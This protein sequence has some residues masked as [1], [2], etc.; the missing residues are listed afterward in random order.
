M[1]KILLLLIFVYSNS[2][3]S[4]TSSGMEQEFDYGIK[5]N[6]TQT[7]TTP[8]YLGTFGTDGTQGKI[9]SAYIEK[10]DNKQN[11]LAI[12]GMGTKYPTVDAVNKNL[13]YVNA[14]SF[15]VLGDG[16]TDDS[17]A[18]QNAINS[19]NIVYFPKGTYNFNNIVVPSNSRIIGDGIGITNFFLN[20]A[21]N[22]LFNI[23][24]DITTVKQNI[25]FDAISFKHSKTH[26]ISGESGVFIVAFR[27]KNSGI[28]N[29]E[30]SEFNAYAIHSQNVDNN[31][32]KTEGITVSN[33]IFRN[34]G[35]TSIGVYFDTETEYSTVNNC[36]FHDLIAVRLINSANNIINGN[37]MLN[38]G[39]YSQNDATLNGGKITFTNNKV[40][41]GGS[42][43]I[44][45][46]NTTSIFGSSIVGN[47]FLATATNGLRLTGGSGNV[48]VGNRFLPVTG[49][50]I[51]LLDYLGVPADN[52]IIT[53]NISVNAEL[54]DNLST[55]VN[56]SIINNLE[57]NLPSDMK[58]HYVSKNLSIGSIFDDGIN[59]LQVNGSTKTTA[60]TLTTTPTTSAG[61]YG[62]LTRNSSTGVVEKVLS[63]S[64]QPALG[65][66]PEN[67]AN[68]SDS[69]TA[70]SSITYASTKAVVDGL[71]TKAPT[72][73]SANYIQNQNASAQSANMW[74]SGDVTANVL[75]SNFEPNNYID[76]YGT[77]SDM[78]FNSQYG[79]PNGGFKFKHAGS[80]QFSINADNSA[81]FASTVT[82]RVFISNDSN[83]GYNIDINK[84]A[85]FGSSLSIKNS[86]SSSNSLIRF[87]KPNNIEFYNL[88]TSSTGIELDG[89]IS[90]TGGTTANQVV[91]K[92]QL[93]GKVS[94]TGNETVAGNKTLSGTTTLN[95]TIIREGYQ[96]KFPKGV[97][98]QSSVGTNALTDN[99]TVSFPDASGT[100]A[101]VE[102]VRPYKVYTAL[103]SQSGT[104]APTATVLENTLA[105]TVVWTR[106]DIGN[107]TATLTGAFPSNKVVV[108][109]TNQPTGGAADNFK[110]G[111][112]TNDTITVITTNGTSSTDS[113]L[114]NSSIEIRV[115]L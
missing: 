82:A 105:G 95:E 104:N 46:A 3:I 90:A 88:Y 65:Y 20:S 2:S 111:R 60:L 17:V 72:T 100:V 28:N 32:T 73:G 66:T 71:A 45:N 68:K 21:T 48:V 1:K 79:N 50:P 23:S 41:H 15:G 19:A 53:G 51:R 103:L 61:T 18:I 5:N 44:R 114:S 76:L 25:F 80:T 38:S 34:A 7:I 84:T 91:V 12:D 69:F 33:S 81:T 24:G 64:L 4:Q 16:V 26:I 115:Y 27:V 101:L 89:T 11:S 109:I 35:L 78:T 42:L 14:K 58:V 77:T 63:T 8:T 29:C 85:G 112:A 75:R 31:A 106:A 54:V 13:T 98:Y 52:N 87:F 74:I 113:L 93:D 102:T 67:V 39:V 62:I 59:K 96:L 86:S 57:N 10:T 6:S 110:G 30:F 9:P 108:F 36:R 55:G 40:N 99:R 83:N 70:S 92:S 107:F 37:M 94:L 43:E 56:N 97:M 49:R 47:E 22:P